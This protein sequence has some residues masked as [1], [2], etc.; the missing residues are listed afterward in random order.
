[1]TAPGDLAVDPNLEEEPEAPAAKRPK[2]NDSQDSTLEDEAVLTALAA[3][4]N[5]TS[6]GEYTT[7]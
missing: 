7:E 6:P 5:E 1:M 4:N 2:L 3:H